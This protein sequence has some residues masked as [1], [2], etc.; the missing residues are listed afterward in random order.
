[1]SGKSEDGIR[2]DNFL[3]QV[4]SII[5]STYVENFSLKGKKKAWEVP[6]TQRKLNKWQF[7]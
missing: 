3:S 5:F 7:L 4:T 1:M 2:D 6:G